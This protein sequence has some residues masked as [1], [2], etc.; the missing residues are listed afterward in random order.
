MS[1]IKNGIVKTMKKNLAKEYGVN[2]PIFVEDIVYAAFKLGVN[3]KAEQAALLASKLELTRYDDGTFYFLAKTASGKRGLTP[4][5]VAFHKYVQHNNETFGFYSGLSYANLVGF[6]L[7]APNIA[8]IT[9]NKV[10]DSM[11]VDIGYARFW[12]KPSK[13]RVDENNHKEIQFLTYLENNPQVFE[14]LEAVQDLSTY[15]KGKLD[16]EIINTFK[17]YFEAKQTKDFLEYVHILTN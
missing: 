14:N 13:V 2:S 9:S 16:K 11:V 6:S 12:V 7:D 1:E 5:Q 10:T 3:L 8:E 4:H 17:P 15:A